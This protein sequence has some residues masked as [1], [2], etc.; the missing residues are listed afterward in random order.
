MVDKDAAH[1]TFQMSS[2]LPGCTGPRDQAPFPESNDHFHS[3]GVKRISDDRRYCW[4]RS[5]DLS[6]QILW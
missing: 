5:R 2:D 1:P 4:I 3:S 6:V